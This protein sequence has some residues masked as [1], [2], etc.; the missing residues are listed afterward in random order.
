MAQAYKI[1]FNWHD[2]SGVTYKVTV[3]NDR[4][5]SF[6]GSDL[7][8]GKIDDSTSNVPVITNIEITGND[9][10]KPH[11]FDFAK[12]F[13]SESMAICFYSNLTEKVFDIGENVFKDDTLLTGITLSPSLRN[14]GSGSFSGCTALTDVDIP[15]NVR[16]I[17]SKAFAGCTG[18]KPVFHLV[19]G[20]Y[21]TIADDA[22]EGSLPM[23]SESASMVLWQGGVEYKMFPYTHQM[24]VVSLTNEVKLSKT[25]LTLAGSFKLNANI[26]TTEM[27]LGTVLAAANASESGAA[28]TG[29]TIGEGLVSIAEGAFCGCY[30]LKSLTLPSTYKGKLTNTMFSTD[31]SSAWSLQSYHIFVDGVPY[32]IESGAG[33][34]VTFDKERTNLCN[35]E[36]KSHRYLPFVFDGDGKEMLY[37]NIEDSCVPARLFKGN[38]S[39]TSVELEPKISAEGE[40]VWHFESVG[41][42]C[43][44]E[45]TA[46]NF[47]ST[48]PYIH[49]FGEGC[50]RGCEKLNSLYIDHVSGSGQTEPL[51][52]RAECFA[53]CTSLAE[54][55]LPYNLGRTDMVLG[56]GMF[57][58][59]TALT[60]VNLQA[61]VN[62]AAGSAY[63]LPARSFEGCDKLQTLRFVSPVSDMAEGALGSK[64]A[65]Q[66][67]ESL[68]TFEYN[69]IKYNIDVLFN[70]PQKTATLLSASV[71]PSEFYIPQVVTLNQAEGISGTIN[72][73]ADKCFSKNTSTKEFTLPASVKVH[74]PSDG[75]DRKTGAGLGTDCFNLDVL[76]SVT[77]TTD[78]DDNIMYEASRSTS[79]NRVMLVALK[80]KASTKACTVKDVHIPAYVVLS[81]I[82]GYVHE[83]S[84]N[85]FNGN[86]NIESLTMDNP[87]KPIPDG[88][89][90]KAAYEFDVIGNS[91][92]NFYPFNNC[93][94]MQ[95]IVF[96]DRLTYIGYAFN[97]LS[98]LEK[99]ELPKGSYWAEN[100]FCN[101]TSLRKLSMGEGITQL[102]Q[103][104]FSGCTSL[105]SVV[106]PTTL[107]VLLAFINSSSMQAVVLPHIN[108]E[109]I[110]P[111][112]NTLLD[113]ND[114]VKIYCSQSDYTN[115]TRSFKPDRL[116]AYQDYRILPDAQFS[117]ATVCLPRSFSQANSY[118]MWKIFTPERMYD[119]Y[120]MA[121]KAINE[122]EAGR[123][124]LI[125]RC[126]YSDPN[127][128]S[129]LNNLVVFG[130]DMSETAVDAPL[131]DDVLVG[132]FTSIEAPT[133]CYLMQG[134]DWFHILT[135]NSTKKLKVGAYRAYMKAN[136]KLSSQVAIMEFDD[137]LTGIKAIDNCQ[138]D[139][140]KDVPV[141]NLNGQ[142]ITTPVKGHIYIVK[143]KKVLY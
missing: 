73:I 32:K 41:A 120:H 20:Q 53:G 5:E 21:P 42:S 88:I 36:I 50:F 122:V 23:T 109:N 71:G 113:V 62:K 24:E 13:A 58:G 94:S 64:K 139:S 78:F 60:S 93:T 47:V 103:N 126:G 1:W 66:S 40:V 69:D 102:S 15:Q 133:P 85:V 48:N 22:F 80:D 125:R 140:S 68:V 111:T 84:N 86:T 105:R 99:L 124:C 101:C 87:Y 10:D 51:T 63:H 3:V 37:G 57:S 90:D 16:Q 135:D 30:N 95:K 108:F 9:S 121:F 118:G 67:V 76:K 29:L 137:T 114:I 43:F 12:L 129:D 82:T 142:R 18:L 6:N 115:V 46:L 8:W 134:D 65:L 59:C 26:Y 52:F 89:K 72:Y 131:D 141:Y 70:Y 97:G 77:F 106:L 110:V 127:Y 34:S 98:A 17:D 35:G 81:N 75:Y 128:V 138:A 39:I 49:T 11:T 38:T 116:L 61:A 19:E 14:I 56:E 96:P 2:P 104:S 92:S 100:V 44:E 130:C 31:A 123:P 54:V 119:D 117:Y 74:V 28:M 132:T 136:S 55:R 7:I 33:Y 91:S 25:E 79:D 107:K 83:I 112:L 143:G 45:C 27:S 4:T